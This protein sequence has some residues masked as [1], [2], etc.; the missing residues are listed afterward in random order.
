MATHNYNLL[1]KYRARTLKCADGR[2]T[3]LE[4]REI[5]FEALEE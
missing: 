3:E 4:Q 1:N 5:D 2:L